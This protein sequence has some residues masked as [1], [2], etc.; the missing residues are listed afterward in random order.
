MIKYLN[1]LKMLTRSGMAEI[2]VILKLLSGAGL[3]AVW[4]PVGRAWY[5]VYPT[6]ARLM[7]LALV[8]FPL[9]TP[10][11]RYAHAESS[12]LA[13]SPAADE[14]PN[15]TTVGV[16]LG[17]GVGAGPFEDFEQAARQTIAGS[18][19]GNFKNFMV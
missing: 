17:V 4:Y 2:L 11:I 1:I 3:L 12:G 16:I 13:P 14:E 19:R 6:T 10:C 15:I 9:T 5:V 7:K 18:K 8:P